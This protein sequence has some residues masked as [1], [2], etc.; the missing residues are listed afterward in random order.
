M[1]RIIGHL[2][3]GLKKVGQLKQTAADGCPS[4]GWGKLSGQVVP[5]PTPKAGPGRR[6]HTLG[7]RT[8]LPGKDRKGKPA[9]GR[10]KDEARSPLPPGRAPLGVP[11]FWS[12]SL[13][14][15]R[16]YSI[17]NRYSSFFSLLLSSTLMILP[18]ALTDTSS[19][20]FAAVT[21]STS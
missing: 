21:S 7:F 2:P 13:K 11:L 10:R 1:R 17:G 6:P 5:K 4:R 15:L 9:F 14:V 8:T 3:Q 16:F 12:R 19:F 20:F 18:S